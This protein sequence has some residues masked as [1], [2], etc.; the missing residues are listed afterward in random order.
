MSEYSIVDMANFLI[1]RRGEEWSV[2]LEASVMSEV[3]AEPEMQVVWA[4]MMEEERLK[5]LSRTNSSFSAQTR[6]GNKIAAGLNGLKNESV[7]GGI[8]GAVGN[9]DFERHRAGISKINAALSQGF[10]DRS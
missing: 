10:L 1:E 6:A 3:E 9:T 2:D 5:H 8:F 7:K 4:S